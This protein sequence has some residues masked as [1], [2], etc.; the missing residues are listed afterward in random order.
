MTQI[1][2]IETTD[3]YGVD[4]VGAVFFRDESTAIQY[5]NTY[6]FYITY[7]AVKV[8]PLFEAKG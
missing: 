4:S 8:Y 5:A 6:D 3:R 1:W 2:V 7:K